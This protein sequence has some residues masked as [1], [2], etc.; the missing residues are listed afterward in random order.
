MPLLLFDID[1][2][3]LRTDGV[4]RR[5]V[6]RGLSELLGVEVSTEGIRFSGKTDPQILREVLE[7]VGADAAWFDDRFDECM[8]AYEEVMV[9]TLLPEVVTDLPGAV[10]LVERLAAQPA[11]HLGLLTGNIR[12]MAYR[13]VAAIGLGQHFAFGAFGCDHED[14]N[15]L[16]AIAAL[17]ARQH[18]GRAFAPTEVVVI[19]DTPRDVECAHAFGARAV[20]VATGNYSREELAAAGPNEL[21]D[22]LADLNACLAAI[23]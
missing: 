18:A 6:E 16:P 9:R 14:R 10:E 11:F 19:G 5:A 22:D 23:S 15:C 20:A 12:T 4:G 8:A 1:G 3:L 17:R 13:K 2:T 7:L 21:L